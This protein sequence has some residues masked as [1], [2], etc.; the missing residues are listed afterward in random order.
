MSN[1]VI[2]K[3]AA[4]IVAEQAIWKDIQVSKTMLSTGIF[5]AQELF[6]QGHS[7]A[8]DYQKNTLL[9][10]QVDAEKNFAETS[11]FESQIQKEFTEICQR[12]TNVCYHD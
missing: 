5:D 1:P 9:W 7:F 8:Y 6:D 12:V 11:R 4:N 3:I 10:G 2:Y